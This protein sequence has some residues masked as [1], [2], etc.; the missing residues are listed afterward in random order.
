MSGSRAGPPPAA[1]RRMAPWLSHCVACALLAGCALAPDPRPP[2][3][4]E[5]SGYAAPGGILAT[6]AGSAMFRYGQAPQEQW[7]R[8]FDSPRIDAIVEE[9]LHA[10]PD[11]AAAAASLRAAQASVRAQR[12]AALPAIDATASLTRQRIPA[13][14][15]SP[16]SSGASI[17]DLHGAQVD[18]TYVPDVFG[19]NR[20]QVEALQAQADTQR[21][22]LDATYLALTANV[23]ATAIQAAALQAQRDFTATLIELQQRQLELTRLQVSAGAA[24]QSA[25]VVQQASLAQAVA[26]LP[27]L[28]RA[29]AQAHDQLCALLG[30]TPDRAGP[31]LPDL[32]AI[33]MPQSIPVALPSQ[34]VEQRPDVRAAAAQLRA[35][36][37][38]VGVA[39]AARLP[40]IT[41]TADI[42]TSATRIAAL[43][44]ADSLLWGIAAGLTQ[45]LFHGGALLERQRAAQ[46]SYEAAV[47]QYRSTALTALR[48][49]A[50]ALNALA[51]DGAAVDA[52]ADLERASRRSLELGRRQ[53]G[54]GDLSP[55]SVLALEQAWRQATINRIQAQATRLADAVALYQ[56]LGGR[57]NEACIA[58]DAE[59]PGSAAS[60]CGS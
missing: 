6:A 39:A 4:P 48:N 35:A 52:A 58:S 23:V 14:L 15:A 49:V 46:A 44:R 5:S 13:A 29:E 25:V 59:R 31:A 33:S 57:W 53:Q 2:R 34:L 8:S 22:Q 50:D 41:L 19:A 26:A 27:P 30:T 28:Q 38:A 20:Y 60:G 1:M 3:L 51:T 56:A 37:A 11:I 54:L 10:S 47:A 16:A 43:G 24:P 32:D 45:P 36:A 12:G 55:L 40:Q 17:Y 9:A 21:E 18:V 42:G 7:W